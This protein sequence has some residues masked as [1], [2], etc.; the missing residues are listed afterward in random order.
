M[1]ARDEIIRK[2]MNP[3][4]NFLIPH[5]SAARTAIA[6]MEAE[7]TS[8]AGVLRRE[9]NPTQNILIISAPS[10]VVDMQ[11]AFDEANKLDMVRQRLRTA[12]Q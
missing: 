1:P 12:G 4:T 8:R 10:A 7:D 11:S 3:D 9:M 5:G 6:Q 2:E